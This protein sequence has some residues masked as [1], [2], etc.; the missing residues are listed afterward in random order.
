MGV[1]FRTDSTRLHFRELWGIHSRLHVFLAAC[2]MKLL[3]LRG[4]RRTAVLHEDLI[5]V[6]PEAD[7]P[8]DGMRQMWP[9][10]DEFERAGARLA[11]YHA[12]SGT[13]QLRGCAAVLLPPERNAFISVTWATARASGRGAESHGFIVSGFSDGTYLATTGSRARFDPAPGV[14]AFRYRGA[15]PE[16]LMRRHQQHLAQSPLP[17]LPVESAAQAERILLAMKRHT[18]EWNVQRGIWVPLTDRELAR[19]GLPSDE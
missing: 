4:P 15:A 9:A 1:Y 18:F 12:V 7:V 16:E 6:I 5:R 19:L 13:G 8:L 14:Q 3:G 10:I 11:F 17:P 2:V